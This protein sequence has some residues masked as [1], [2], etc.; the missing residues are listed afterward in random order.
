M[1][2]HSQLK[3]SSHSSVQNFVA[4]EINGDQSNTDQYEEAQGKKR[5]RQRGANKFDE[6]SAQIL[7]WDSLDSKERRR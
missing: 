2:M 4:A 3:T 5:S 1:E 6:I 7:N